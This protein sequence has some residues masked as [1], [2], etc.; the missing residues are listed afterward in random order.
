MRD[1]FT[2]LVGL[3]TIACGV[4]WMVGLA[5]DVEIPW[6][7]VLPVALVAIGAL[8]VFGR[9]D[10]GNGAPPSQFERDDAPRVP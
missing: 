3:V 1:R 7:W 5:T 9:S 8:L 6:E 2:V 4:L 10:P